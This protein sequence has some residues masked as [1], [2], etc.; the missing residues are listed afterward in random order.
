M[1]ASIPDATIGDP[2]TR[3]AR[4]Y[5]H[6][7]GVGGKMAECPMTRRDRSATAGRLRADPAAP[8]A[9][10]TVQPLARPPAAPPRV[11]TLTSW[12]GNAGTVSM[13][14][15]QFV[16]HVKAG[17]ITGTLSSAPLRH[18]RHVHRLEWEGTAVLDRVVAQLPGR[19]RV[20]DVLGR[21]RRLVQVHAAE[22]LHVAADQ[23]P[24]VRARDGPHL[25]LR[26]QTHGRRRQRGAQPRPEQGQASTTA[27]R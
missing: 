12:M 14:Y 7:S 2:E 13:E 21:E 1:A 9:T 8:G 18:L 19:Y 20:H 23:H 27:R 22:R 24:A 5:C 26:L 25:L 3:A 15:S 6:I 16:D 4:P 10:P 11:P 17:D